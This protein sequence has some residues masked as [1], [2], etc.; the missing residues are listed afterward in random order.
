[1]TTS[2]F[3]ITYMAHIIFL[4]DNIVPE[5]LHGLRM[6]YCDYEMEGQR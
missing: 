3:K 4:S 1:M 5:D 6:G 2:K